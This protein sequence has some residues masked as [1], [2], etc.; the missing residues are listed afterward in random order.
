MTREITVAKGLFAPGHLGELTRIVPF[1][2]VDAVL[3]ET[4]ASQRRLR[5][6]PARVVV[7]LLLAATLF[8]ECGYPGVWRKL[9]AALDSIPIPTIT[10]AALWDARTRLGVRPMRALFDLLRGP[11]SAIRTNGARWKG[12]LTVAIDGTYL[13][14]P[15]S[16]MHRT[17]LGK[18]S[19]Q[20]ATSGY[21]QICL[22][23]LVACG[24]RAVIDAAFGPRSSGETVY[25]KRLMRSLHHGM[26]VLLDRGFA[27]NTFLT[28]VAGTEAAFVA[29]LSAIRKPPVLARYDDGSFLSRLGHLDVRVIECEITITTPTGRRTG[30]YRLATSLLDAR[31]YPALD[32]VRLYHERWE[33]ESAYFE[34]KKSMLGR[35]VLRSKTWAGIA[36]E[37]YALL[38]TYQALRIAI[39]D[40]TG[41]VPNTDPD[42]ASFS[43][44][45]QTARD[46]II[47]AAGVIADTVIDLVGTIGRA[48]LDQLMP[49]RRLRVSPRAVK[50]P[51]SR[52]AYKSL[53]VDRHT[54]QATLSIN[55]VTPT[56]SP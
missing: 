21:P 25:G 35:R 28:A 6:L 47:Q 15:D 24:T 56:I 19:N 42:R 16:P 45:L 55:I 9:T 10:G 26:I 29:R 37:V 8:E 18:G 27:T 17:R 13:D 36:Q 32:L 48:V 14:V 34:I 7:Y 23:T 53:K 2:M 5:K 12:M 11:A 52:Y 46:Q 31:R 20:Y 51:L 30:L 40:A 49:T 3:A 41:T 39:T 38:S 1:E 22:T 44:A 50:R 33:T 43:I 4:N 54:Y